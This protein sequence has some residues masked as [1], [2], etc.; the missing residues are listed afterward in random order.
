MGLA[1]TGY[2]VLLKMTEDFQGLME[3]MGGVM[4]PS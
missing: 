4:V 2:V 3:C 1:V